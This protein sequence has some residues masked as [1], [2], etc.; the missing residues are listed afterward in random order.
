MSL[1]PGTQFMPNKYRLLSLF[2]EFNSVNLDRLK[3]AFF[4]ATPLKAFFLSKLCVCVHKCA[5]HT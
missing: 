1:I 2:P 3:M 4:L 5:G